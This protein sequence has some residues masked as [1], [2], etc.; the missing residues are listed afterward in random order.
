MVL[1]TG[2]KLQGGSY[3]IKE[4]L[5]DGGGGF[6][7]AYLAEGKEGQLL[8]IKTLNDTA[9]QSNSEKLKRDFWYEAERLSRF[10]HSHIVRFENFFIEK[11]HNEMLCCIV[12]E[13][14]K[15][16]TLESY[17]EKSG[18]ISETET[19]R[20][21]HQIGEALT[22]VHREGLLHRDVKPRNIMLRSASSDSSDNFEAVLIDF[23]IA[24][25]F[26]PGQKQKHTTY[27]SKGYA[28]IEQYQ[29]QENRNA[30]TDVYA[31]AATLYYLLTK[32]E[33]LPALERDFNFSRNQTD[34]LVSPRQINPRISDHVNEAIVWGMQLK[35]KDRPQS[36]EE[37][38][39]CFK[40]GNLNTQPSRSLVISNSSPS[41]DSTEQE[42][43]PTNDEG[44]ITNDAQSPVLQPG[45]EPS[46]QPPP[47]PQSIA[48]ELWRNVQLSYT[49]TGHS[50]EVNAVASSPDGQTLVSASS[51]CTVKLWSLDTGELIFTL[52]G[53]S[54]A[55]F[56][57]AISTDGRTLVS[58]DYDYKIMVWNLET[59]ELIRTL[60]GHAGQVL[61]V[62][63]SPDGKTLV[64]GSIDGT[65]KTWHLDT[66]EPIRTFGNRF[67]QQYINSYKQHVNPLVISLDGKTIINGTSNSTVKVWCLY[68]GEQLRL[69]IPSKKSFWEKYVNSVAL[70]PDNQILV[71]NSQEEIQVWNFASGQ[72]L[73]KLTGHCGMVSCVAISP[74]GQT[75]AS[76]CEDC[77]VKLW[78]LKTGRII[79][80]LE[81]HESPVYSVT[82]S[83]D[84]Q[85]L[86]SGSRDCKIKIW[87]VPL[88]SISSDTI[89]S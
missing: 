6:G 37:W 70:S 13:Y 43:K 74:D 25:E 78:N 35:A 42:P 12:M 58:G 81:E 32:T 76:S 46:P 77:M 36:V 7:I 18:I 51:D 23:G 71:S 17:V 3:T 28:P 68:K 47:S 72:L 39:E 80:T 26:K 62:A 55:V 33:P 8:V 29:E 87:R 30:C 41:P 2:Q 63:I 69:L 1:E 88:N 57:V 89:P 56:C 53:H 4:K 38:L 84:G 85:S 16:Q 64:S 11:L 61:S 31:L 67:S 75:L 15:G 27:H 5:P 79:H 19:L 83:P 44:L 60:T 48:P 10:S 22:V 34:P 49:L 45:D 9:L 14:I 40:N 20:Y 73:H 82:F 66:G 65:I 21:I 59:R 52:N 50:K 54:E 24:R 86:I